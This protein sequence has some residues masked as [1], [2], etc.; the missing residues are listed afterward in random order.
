MK[1]ETL[2]PEIVKLLTNRLSNEYSAQY[3]YQHLANWCENEGYLVASEFFKNESNDELSHA[4]KI[5]KFMTDWNVLPV[6]PIIQS[7]KAEISVL[8]DCINSAYAA[9]LELYE[10]Y[11]ETSNKI[12]K[13]GDTCVFDFLMF[14]RDVQQKS[15]AEYATK[16]NMLNGIN[17]NNKFEMLSIEKKLF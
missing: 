3:L 9:E 16:L 13:I 5:Q 14:F 17:V 2:S 6:L 12:L 8:A 4:K 11:E 15:V 10:L 7:P 1:L